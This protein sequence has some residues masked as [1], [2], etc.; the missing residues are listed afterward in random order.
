[1]TKSPHQEGDELF[2][3]ST[4]PS[5]SP[6]DALPLITPIKMGSNASTSHAP[7]QEE[8]CLT[9]PYPH[10]ALN[11]RGVTLR[12]KMEVILTAKGHLSTTQQSLYSAQYI[13]SPSVA[14]LALQGCPKGKRPM[15]TFVGINNPSRR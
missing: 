12:S 1:M 3:T 7:H 8:G 10:D 11:D 13:V 14:D 2:I 6:Q 9:A 4:I 5:L 15:G